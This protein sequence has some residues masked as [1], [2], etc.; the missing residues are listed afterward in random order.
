MLFLI[1]KQREKKKWFFFIFPKDTQFQFF[2]SFT[3][4]K[5]PQNSKHL[6]RIPLNN[7]EQ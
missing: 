5:I 6:F 1:G 7:H 2:K 4:K 3:P